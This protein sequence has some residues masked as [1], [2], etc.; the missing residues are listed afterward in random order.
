MKRELFN[1]KLPANLIAHEPASERR[2]SMMM[3]IDQETNDIKHRS[4]SEI[5]SLVKPGDLMVFNNTKVMPARMFG[6]KDTGGKIE[7]LVERLIDDQTVLGHLRASK[8]PKIGSKI[9]F[10]GC[11]EALIQERR[12]DLFIIKFSGDQSAIDALESNGHTPLPPY[13]DRPDHDVDKERYQTV[14]A[15]IPGAVAAPTAGL[16]FDLEILQELSSLGINIAYVTLHVGSGTFQPVR[17]SSIY[18]HVMHSEVI[19]VP[20]S[21]CEQVEATRKNGGRVIAIGTTSVRCLESAA[22]G[23]KISPMKGET[24]IFIY[25]GYKFQIVDAMVTNFHLPESTLLMLVCAFSGYTRIMSAYEQAIIKKYRFFSYGDAMFL[26]NNP[27]AHQE[28]PITDIY[29]GKN[30][31]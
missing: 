24:D 8:S 18:D 29:L 13:I 9:I 5:V 3:V 25:P 20:L 17:E 2:G 12:E 1:Y 16:H 27:D 7:L 28:L 30:L 15:K 4:F 22:S 26:I 10:D 19:D 23:G 14:Y 21:V 6:K 31:K 11:I